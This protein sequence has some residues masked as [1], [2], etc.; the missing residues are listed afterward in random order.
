MHKRIVCQTL[1]DVLYCS[2]L[3]IIKNHINVNITAIYDIL[4][5]DHEV[6]ILGER[7]GLS[8]T[9]YTNLDSF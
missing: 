6:A 8:E 5:S 7:N 1:I 3:K 9:E 4:T 2:F